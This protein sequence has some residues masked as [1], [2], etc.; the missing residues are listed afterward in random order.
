MNIWQLQSHITKKKNDFV[1][2]IAK[3]MRGTEIIQNNIPFLY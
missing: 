2:K 3:R 1:K